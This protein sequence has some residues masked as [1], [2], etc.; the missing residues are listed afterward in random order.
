[1]KKY[2]SQ[3][4]CWAGI[5]CLGCLTHL[6]FFLDLCVYVLVSSGLLLP[7]RWLPLMLCSFSLVRLLLC[8]VYL[9]LG[10]SSALISI[11]LYT[12][13]HA[14]FI[15]W[16]MMC[17]SRSVW[18]CGACQDPLQ[19]TWLSIGT[20]QRATARSDWWVH[21]GWLAYWL[22]VVHEQRV[23]LFSTLLVH[24]SQPLHSNLTC[25]SLWYT[26]GHCLFSTTDQC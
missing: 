25:V 26:Q 19:Q 3:L 11:P 17:S 12:L 9:V 23:V 24:P 14:Y 13:N 18:W 5:V 4:S 6:T 15:T 20:V 7:Y 10:L 8:C 16:S 2:V 1:M 22:N 21:S